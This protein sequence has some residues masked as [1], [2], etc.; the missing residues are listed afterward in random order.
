[1]YEKFEKL[2]KEHGHTIYRVA[3][4]TG[5]PTS[6]LYDWRSGRSTPRASTLKKIAA[7]YGVPLEE[8]L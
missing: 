2:L 6:V 1:L 5:I 8:L 3:K 4:E 7:F